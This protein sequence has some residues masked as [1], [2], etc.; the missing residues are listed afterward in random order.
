MIATFPSPFVIL[1]IMIVFVIAG[2]IKGSLGVGFPAFAMSVFPIFIDSSFGVTILAIPILLTNFMQFFTVKGWQPIVRR[3]LLAGGVILVTTFIVAQ[4]AADVSSRWINI[5]VGLSLTLFALSSLF[6]V[7]IPAKENPRWQIGVGLV[8]GLI[9]GIAA[10]T[11]PVMVYAVALKMPR[12][13]FMAAGGFMFFTSGVG[14]VAGLSTASALNSVTLT[15]SLGAV[16][17]SLIGFRIGAWI[18]PKLSERVFRTALLW[19]IL[20]LGLRLTLVNII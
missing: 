11:A 15:L 9:G 10:V 4:L 17:V 6:K 2:T 18:R 12:E 8:S 13:E 20:A 16:V 14:L 5:I 3:F 1:A 7:N 19:T